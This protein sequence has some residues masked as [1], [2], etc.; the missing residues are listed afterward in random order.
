MRKST[1]ILAPV[2]LVLL[3]ASGS[4][5][6]AGKNATLSVTA[7]ISKT[8]CDVNLTR[9]A[10]DLGNFVKSDFN[11][12]APK[13]PIKSDSVTVSLANCADA[14]DAGTASLVIAGD[15]LAAH[16]DMFSIA[17]ADDVA[18]MIADQDAATTY[19]KEK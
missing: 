5:L 9:D 6:A 12:I 3:A 7:N 15:T 11:S 1:F 10:I 16:A 14:A 13:T 19:I 8:T 17:P 4:A 18:I 2:A